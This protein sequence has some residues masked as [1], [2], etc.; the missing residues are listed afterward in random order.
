MFTPIMDDYRIPPRN[1]WLSNSI[2]DALTQ[3]EAELFD[4]LSTDSR[5]EM[6]IVLIDHCFSE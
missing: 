1:L 6:I 4:E 5:N 3:K 2:C